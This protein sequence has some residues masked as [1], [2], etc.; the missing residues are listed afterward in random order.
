MTKSELRNAYLA[1]RREL[2]ADERRELS[3][4][5]CDRFFETVDLTAVRY[6]HCFLPIDK[7]NEID[8]TL[9]V[10][11]VWADHPQTIT[12]VPR[13][14][15]TSGAME[16]VVYSDTTEL[17]V[18][19]WGIAEPASTDTI[20]S[21]NIDLVVVPLLAFDVQGHRV[22]YGRAYYDKFLAACAP[23]C[24]KIGVSYF[25]P[26]DR[27]DNIAEH[28]IRLDTCVTPERVYRF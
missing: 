27:I 16:S 17:V 13:I 4:Q 25:A 2:A 19:S 1:K 5:I 23:E 20:D 10:G 8:T 6:L 9:I 15:P 22:G 3:R 12:V 18:N 14:D 7:F 24:R 11:R 26:V 28:D 21:E